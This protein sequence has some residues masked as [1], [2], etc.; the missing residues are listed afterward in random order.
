MNFGK[1]IY[2]VTCR[3]PDRAKKLLQRARD[4]DASSTQRVWMKSA[5]T[6]R[7]LGNV[8]GETPFKYAGYPAPSGAPSLPYQVV[9]EK[10]NSLTGLDTPYNSESRFPLIPVTQRQNSLTGLVT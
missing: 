5:I 10:G 6:E 3:E 9:N 2:A 4:R 7:E 1:R 8:K